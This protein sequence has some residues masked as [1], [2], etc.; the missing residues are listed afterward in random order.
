M[1]RWTC[2]NTRRDNVRNEVTRTKIDV[3]SIE[4]KM[5]ENHLRWFGYVRHRPTVH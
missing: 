1:L 2:D 4:A 3:A 5:R